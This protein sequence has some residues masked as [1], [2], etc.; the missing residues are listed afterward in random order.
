[1]Q[2]V[3][4][5]H[6][7][8]GLF[9]ITQ[10]TLMYEILLTRIFSVTMWYHFAFMAISIAMFGMTAG[11]VLVYFFPEYFKQ[12]RTN[13][14][15]G[16]FSLLFA[17]STIISF[18][19][20]LRIPF[21][22]NSPLRMVS[23]TY[24][25]TAIPFLFSGI[26]VSLALTRF[27]LQVS[28]LYAAD[29]A[30]A[31]FGCIALIYS[32]HITDGPT[33][34]LILTFLTALGSFL[35]LMRADNRWFRRFAAIC[36]VVLAVLTGANFF[37]ERQGSGLFK[38]RWAK[39]SVESEP[40]YERWNSYSRVRVI[41]DPGPGRIFG[42]G[43][44][45]ILSPVQS[46]KELKLDIDAS[47]ATVLTEF[48][49][50][51]NSVDF[52]R[53]DV[54]NMVH[55]IRPGSRVL[56]IGAGG[57]RDVLSALVFGQDSIVGVEMNNDILKAV[58]ERF[59]D[60]TGHL[61]RNPKV[62]FVNEE[63][64]SYVAAQR[65]KFG[66]IQASLIDTYAATAA[67]AFVLSENSLYTVEAWKMFLEHLEPDGILTFSRWYFPRPGQVY[68]LTSIA[69]AAL[70]ELGIK[71]PRDH[72]VVVVG[73]QSQSI[74]M[75]TILV[76]KKPF[77]KKDLD[78]IKDVARKMHFH[79]A[80]S[81]RFSLDPIFAAIASGA[82]SSALSET[83]RMDISPPTD[84][85]P[86]FFYMQKMKDAFTTDLPEQGVDALFVLGTLMVLVFVLTLLCIFVPLFLKARH[87]DRTGSWPL[88]LYFA[89]I[90]FGFLLIEISQMQ[91][92]IIFLG[93]PTYSLSVVLFALLLSSGL[94]SY[95]TRNIEPARLNQDA[96]RRFMFLLAALVLLGVITPNIP[97]FF[98]GFS[99]SVRI[100]IAI[101]LLFPAGIFMGM[102]F[103]IG[104]KLVSD[105]GDSM[106]PWLWGINGATSVCASVLAVVIA[107]SF[108]ISATFWCG[109][110]FYVVA[111]IALVMI[112][113][114]IQ[115]S[116]SSTGIVAS[117]P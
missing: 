45:P 66:I 41:E 42:W 77:S 27:P 78:A 106:K 57:G 35:F 46:V 13:D 47:A 30:G 11:A 25:V 5:K 83:L 105:E 111:S 70:L 69:S 80:L 98:Q 65:E 44:S 28:K 53:Y 51:L 10:A 109:V 100:L 40:L 97:R 76:S 73:G 1:M 17:V 8:A 52:L 115:E 110:A 96:F 4:T 55:Y 31:A 68:R 114:P 61:S 37:L 93:H 16:L 63:A 48:H 21:L 18:W 14:H 85:R 87:D 91:R 60:F 102:A 88:I 79:I 107:L 81:P 19:I 58:N 64:R 92:L 43:L 89:A 32:L 94:G 9:L 29:L 56:V 71:H 12:E 34:V 90:G 113:K 117:V 74:P 75:G 15:L 22:T 72:I 3:A 49:G 67:G 36:C 24:L 54:T 99:N 62:T 7:Y 38:L 50:D 26:C 95:L 84:D 108:G 23:F 20:D 2:P 6:T 101:I 82:N 39:G 86:F 112:T 104:M 116:E 59:G 33:T 103:P